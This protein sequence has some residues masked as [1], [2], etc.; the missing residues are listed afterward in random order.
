VSKSRDAIAVEPALQVMGGRGFESVGEAILPG[1]TVGILGGG[2]LGRMLAMVARRSGYRVHVLAD[3]AGSPASHFAHKTV[4]AADD[5]RA[6]WCHFAETCDVVT[7]EF[8][9]LP[10]LRVEEICEL[11]PVRPGLL[12][13]ETAQNRAAEKTFLD[14]CGLPLPRFGLLSHDSDTGRVWDE[15]ARPAAVLKTAGGGYDG[16]GQAVVH[17]VHELEHAWQRLGRLPCTLEQL[18][19]LECEIS[20][21]V[22]RDCRGETVTYGP[23]LNQHAHHILDLTVFPAGVDDA[24][25]SA[26]CAFAVR[27][28]QRLELVGLVCVEFFVTRAGE[29]LVNEIAPRPHNSGH[30]TI[31]AFACSQF[32]QQ[33]RCVCGL[34]V[35]PAVPVRPAA[36]VNLLGDLWAGGEP[37]WERLAEFPSCYLHLYDKNPPRPGRKMGH[38]TVCAESSALA[39]ELAIAARK[40]IVPG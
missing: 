7:M 31:E 5:D 9:N 39:G 19:D 38:L 18:V 25:E 15:V 4:V 8:E 14:S 12:V 1:Q 37:N 3:E 28:A 26:A 29:V 10:A 23:L 20:V 34:P 16:K 32:E 2:Q 27:V 24:V 6:A 30:L 36:M 33:L 35:A 40:A 11:V 17:S 21:L 13:L 22:A